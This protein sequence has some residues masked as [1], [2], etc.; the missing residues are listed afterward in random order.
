VIKISLFLSY[1]Y[2][3]CERSVGTVFELPNPDAIYSRDE[4]KKK[5]VGGYPAFLGWRTTHMLAASGVI[6]GRKRL[7]LR[8]KQ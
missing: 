2:H 7:V 5:N 8:C 1:N 3:T 6:E 4:E